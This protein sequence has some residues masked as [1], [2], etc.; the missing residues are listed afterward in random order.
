MSVDQQITKATNRHV[1][2]CLTQLEE[3]GVPQV[4]LDAVKREFWYLS[5]DVKQV[6]SES[7]ETSHESN[8]THPTD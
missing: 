7:R 5:D 2:R 8:T 1:G 6:L 4:C 3:A